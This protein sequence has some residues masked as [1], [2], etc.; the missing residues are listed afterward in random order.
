M[1]RFSLSDWLLI[2]LWRFKSGCDRVFRNAAHALA[3]V[4]RGLPYAVGRQTFHFSLPGRLVVDFTDSVLSNV[5]TLRCGSLSTP[6]RRGAG[7]ADQPILDVGA[8]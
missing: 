1:V 5:E 2:V 4:L 3:H 8:G 6:L 7:V